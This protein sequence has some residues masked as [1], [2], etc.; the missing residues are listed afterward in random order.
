MNIPN[1]NNAY[2][3]LKKT[4]NNIYNEKD[5]DEFFILSKILGYT[6]NDILIKDIKKKKK[7]TIKKKLKQNQKKNPENAIFLV[8]IFTLKDMNTKN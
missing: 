4:M 2:I 6:D 3:T 5:W 7:M 1:I 8:L